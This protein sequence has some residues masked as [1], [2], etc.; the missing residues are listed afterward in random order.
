[1]LI[2][3]EDWE[4]Q[5]AAIIMDSEPKIAP[6]HHILRYGVGAISYIFC[7]QKMRRFGPVY[8]D[9]NLRRGTEAPL[10]KFW[11]SSSDVIRT[12]PSRYEVWIC[13]ALRR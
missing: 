1:M 10:L 4:R 9:P 7:K 2:A 8:V 12:T 5:L 6:L 11:W 3:M 13:T